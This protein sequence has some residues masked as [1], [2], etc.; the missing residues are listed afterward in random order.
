M[1]D[2]LSDET[3]QQKIRTM[4]TEQDVK[5]WVDQLTSRLA[6]HED[7][8]LVAELITDYFQNG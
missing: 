8:E 3:L 6:M 2:Y 1:N 7:D 5:R 4:K